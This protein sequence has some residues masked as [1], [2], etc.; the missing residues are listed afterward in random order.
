MKI[1]FRQKLFLPLFLSWICLLAGF[2][3]NIFQSHTLR[4]EERKIQLSNAGEIATSIAKEYAALAAAG[5]LACDEAKKEA[6]AR[7]RALRYGASGYIVSY[8]DNV[9]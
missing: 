5:T 4:L 8:N 9:V 6:L 1:T 3:V 2:S 7:I